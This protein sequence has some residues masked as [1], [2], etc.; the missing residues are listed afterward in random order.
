MSGQGCPCVRPL[1]NRRP[2]S[3]GWPRPTQRCGSAQTFDSGSRHDCAKE[4]NA[5][6]RIYF[7]VLSIAADVG[8]VVSA[9]GRLIVCASGCAASSVP[10]VSL[11]FSA[12]LRGAV[13][14]MLWD[15]H[16]LAAAL[17]PFLAGVAKW[18]VATTFRR[19]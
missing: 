7:S 8:G 10:V 19:N 16:Q 5:V 2:G 3:H 17:G 1:D 11:T 14:R 13:R 4:S 12:L 6:N 9:A 18:F 15:T